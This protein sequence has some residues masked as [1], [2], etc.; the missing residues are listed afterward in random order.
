MVVTSITSRIS[1]GTG[2]VVVVLLVAVVTVVGV[3]P[4]DPGDGEHATAFNRK[5]ITRTTVR[6]RTGA[7]STGGD[8]PLTAA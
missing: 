2:G 5:G 7:E 8:L 6:T 3:A 4:E 1:A